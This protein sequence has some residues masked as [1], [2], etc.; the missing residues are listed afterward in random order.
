MAKLSMGDVQIK[1]NYNCFAGIEKQS[2]QL[3]E[4]GFFQLYEKISA[5]QNNHL[6]SHIKQFV[7]LS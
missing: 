3:K 5:R 4:E 1:T 2:F 6:L 7:D